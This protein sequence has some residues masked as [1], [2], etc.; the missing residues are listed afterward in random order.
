MRKTIRA[1]LGLSAALPALAG[2][3]SLG[4]PDVPR[5]TAEQGM[6]WLRILGY[7]GVE[8]N[9]A[10]GDGMCQMSELTMR[11]YQDGARDTVLWK[12]VRKLY[13]GLD[14]LTAIGNL[15]L[16]NRMWVL[17][18][19]SKGV[20]A[21]RPSDGGLVFSTWFASL[22]KPVLVDGHP[23]ALASS[24][25][26]KAWVDLREGGYKGQW[27]ASVD[28][29]FASG[30]TFYYVGTDASGRQNAVS[31]P[32]GKL[33]SKVWYAK[34]QAVADDDGDGYLLAS[35]TAGDDP[36]WLDPKGR[37]VSRGE[38][39]TVRGMSFAKGVGG[40]RGTN[41]RGEWAQ[42]DLKGRPLGKGWQTGEVGSMQ[43][44]DGRA[45]FR[46][47]AGTCTFVEAKSGDDLLPRAFPGLGDKVWH[48]EGRD[49][50]VARDNLGRSTYLDALLG[51][52]LS[53][54]WYTEVG[55]PDISERLFRFDA[56]KINGQRVRMI[57]TPEG[58]AEEQA[59]GAGSN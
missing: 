1:L 21:V 45:A 18:Q 48:F 10:N 58:R 22:S 36:A 47:C 16:G 44:L 38:L 7:Q 43:V 32:K 24:S 59:P 25:G 50:I 34:V 26:G 15:R 4:V 40:L 46:S 6:A 42:L 53:S 12:E 52:P 54:S 11:D 39:V 49:I 3:A 27:F 13:D 57:V 29:V 31:L 23:F 2:A 33:V 5:A 41:A 14:G 51:E 28:S 9:D 56:V 8:F 30:E 55:E 19:G 17:A 35:A 20:N 37:P